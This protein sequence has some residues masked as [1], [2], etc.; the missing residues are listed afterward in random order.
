M[1]S[2]KRNL[3]VVLIAFIVLFTVLALYFVYAVTTYGTRWFTN[4]Y[5]TRLSAQ[6]ST[7][8]AG[9]ILDRNRTVLAT[10]KDSKRVYN[11]DRLLREAV[12]HVVG[13]NYGLTS[14]GA[15]SFQARYLLGFNTNIFERVYESLSGRSSKGSDI[16]LT[17]DAE[18]C[19]Y[20]SQ[21]MGNYKGAVVVMN[22]VT[23]EILASV[24]HPMFDP[25]NMDEYIDLSSK[26]K[27]ETSE[28]TTALVNRATMGKY[29]PG[30]VF[31]LITAT[32]ALR[33][34]NDADTRKWDCFGPLAFD[35]N[36]GH[37]LENIRLT[38]KEDEALLEAESSPQDTSDTANQT[39]EGTNDAPQYNLLRDYS[40]DYHG[41]ITLK[42]AFAKSCNH[43][44]AMIAQEVGAARM[45]RTAE[46]FGFG[47][48]FMFQ[49]MML[50]SSSYEK[51]AT[52]F[53]TAWSGVGQYKDVITPLHMAMIAASIA[54]DGNMME[55]KLL[56]GI[57]NSRNYMTNAV[58]PVVHSQPLTKQEAD[59]LTE[60]MRECIVSG[61][62]K[63]AAH[64]KYEVCG[65][66]GTAEVSGDKTVGNHAWFVGFINN[67][68]H[69]IA[70]AVVLENAGSGGGKAAPLAGDVIAKAIKLGY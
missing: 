35:V 19:K 43:T 20:A 41:D 55:P 40:S 29:T 3:R 8:T 67:E 59:K 2:I 27:G 70:I 31:K 5:N 37:L 36:S 47:E 23:G 12:S 62:G 45:A 64:S 30:S 46:A 28:D 52:Q 53:D 7:V 24:S 22:Y 49:D 63:S 32:A 18:L 1:K 60:Y 14:S 21:K 6:K 68:N 42:T 38:Q 11:E 4:P 34:I 66:T 44:F 61:T 48:N 50:Y 33:Y 16:I 10:T 65:K 56:R 25:A 39:A 57:I 15:E 54:N 58:K 69:P 13:D 26:N 17:I 51:G 9:D